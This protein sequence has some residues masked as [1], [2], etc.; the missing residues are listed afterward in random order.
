[1]RGAPA[2]RIRQTLEASSARG[3]RGRRALRRFETL[4]L[5]FGA[6]L[7]LFRQL[8]LLLLEHL[9][10][11][12]RTVEGLAEVRKRQAEG[13]L[14]VELVLDHDV[15]GR[16]LLDLVDGLGAHLRLGEATV[17]EADLEG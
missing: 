3:W 10:I 6:L 8:L 17:R 11:D 5:F 15:Q 9:R 7:Q 4:A 13:H 12:R 16:A 1:M 14:V 2:P